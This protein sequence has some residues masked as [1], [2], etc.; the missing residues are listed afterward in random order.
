ME[1][2]CVWREGLSEGVVVWRVCIWREG[3]SEGV[4]VWRVYVYGGRGVLRGLLY[5]G[6]VY[7]EVGVF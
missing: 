3:L 5:G 4:V 2:V 7:M 6:C 1:G